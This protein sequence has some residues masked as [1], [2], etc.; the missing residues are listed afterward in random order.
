LTTLPSAK[1]KREKL[2]RKS[3]PLIR[4]HE[5]AD[6]KFLWAAYQKGSFQLPEGLSQTDFL[7]EMQKQFGDFDLLWVIEDDHKGFRSGRGQV[8]LVGVKTDG[9]AYQPSAAFFKW[10]TPKNVLR[11]LVGFFQMIRHQKIGVCRVEVGEKDM[12][13][14]ARL[15]EY[16]VLFL[17][18]RIPF[19]SPSGDSFVFS[20]NGRK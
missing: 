15:K 20:I 11:S 12:K 16:G 2:F 10:A 9:W 6:N 3:R 8:C 18:G 13:T 4:K 17:R 1:T 5:E 14:L 7:I 19:G